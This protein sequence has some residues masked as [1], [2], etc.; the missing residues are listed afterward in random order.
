MQK[1]VPMIVREH[2]GPRLASLLRY[3]V[4]FDQRDNPVFPSQGIMVKSSNEYCGLGGNVA[5]ISNNT[6]AEVSVPLFSGFVAQL[7][8]R[9]GIIKETRKTTV[10]PLSN[11]FYCGGPLTLRGFEFGGAGP[12]VDGTPIGAQ[13]Y[14]IY[15][16]NYL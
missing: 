10:L 3:S 4:I 9:I 2:C 15:S 16:N 1:N 6:H 5:Y 14:L 12:I 11:L 13:V 7:C 8:G